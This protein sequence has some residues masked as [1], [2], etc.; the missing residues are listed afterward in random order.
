MI[1]MVVCNLVLDDI[2]LVSD[3]GWIMCLLYVIV[4]CRWSI[5]PL[6]ISGVMYKVD[7]C[8]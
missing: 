5:G 6:L 8:G 7:C 2:R 3:I 1:N 4:W